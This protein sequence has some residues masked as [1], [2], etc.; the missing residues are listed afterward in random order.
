[1]GYYHSFPLPFIS[2][3]SLS[4]CPTH[5]P[6]LQ[7]LLLSLFLILFVL[8]RLLSR[9]TYMCLTSLQCQ[10]MADFR[11]EVNEI[12]MWMVCSWGRMNF[13]EGPPDVW[14]VYILHNCALYTLSLQAQIVGWHSLWKHTCSFTT[15]IHSSKLLSFGDEQSKNCF[16]MS[17]SLLLKFHWV[18]WRKAFQI[19]S[20]NSSHKI[21]AVFDSFH[22]TM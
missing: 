3:S 22:N 18:E 20:W 15:L 9:K 14:P 1:M 10:R 13:Q 21:A 11:G 16:V 2:F 17:L 12:S 6:L 5:S 4:L 7:Q 19:K 8:L